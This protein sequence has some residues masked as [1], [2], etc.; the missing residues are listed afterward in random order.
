M[1]D[2]LGAVHRVVAQCAAVSWL[3]S[4]AA[5][6]TPLDT[7]FGLCPDLYARFREFNAVFWERRLVDPVILELC[8]LRV[9][10]LLHCRSEL[11][12]RYRPA[13]DAG[14]SEEKVAV[15]EGWRDDAR[16]SDAE[17]ACLGFAEKFVTDPHAVTDEEAGA[18]VAQ[19]GDAGT[20]ALTEALALFDGFCRLRRVLGVEP[21][22]DAVRVVPAPA[23]AA[24]L[25]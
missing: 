14:L 21:A 12:V 1:S 6:D 18:V 23:P 15:L 16:F 13:R 4:R 5:G 25:H 20:V 11:C 3:P 2:P 22:D 8:R 17:R 7:V 19:L 24:S 9:A 10:T